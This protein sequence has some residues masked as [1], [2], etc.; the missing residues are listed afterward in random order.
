MTDTRRAT[1]ST[2]SSPS[3]AS[4]QTR[5]LIPLRPSR[6]EPTDHR[7]LP[8]SV[9]LARSWRS[10]RPWRSPPDGTK[11]E[12]TSEDRHRPQQTPLVLREERVAPFDGR[13]DRSAGT[14]SPPRGLGKQIERIVE[15]RGDVLQ[16]QTVHPGSGAASPDAARQASERVL[17]GHDRG[18]AGVHGSRRNHRP[19]ARARSRA[20]SAARTCGRAS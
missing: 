3:G 6:G 8:F 4:K 19:L 17:R 20:A 9:Y 13:A 1:V 12:P 2:T 11:I 16:V 15:V 14:V 18:A 10:G 7:R 5:S